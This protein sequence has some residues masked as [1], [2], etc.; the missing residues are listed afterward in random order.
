MINDTRLEF[1]SEF[2]TLIPD[3]A[4]ARGALESATRAVRL[5]AHDLGRVIAAEA[6]LREALKMDGIR[7]PR[8]KFNPR[9]V[10]KT[11]VEIAKATGGGS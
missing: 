1:D 2:G 9:R 10:I 5:A 8:R 4:E 6:R 11:L 3:A 7:A